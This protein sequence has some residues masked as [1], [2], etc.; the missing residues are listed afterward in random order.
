MSVLPPTFDDD[1]VV[2]PQYD[3]PELIA[4]YHLHDYF[5]NVD[6]GEATRQRIVTLNEDD[7]NKFLKINLKSEEFCGTHLNGLVFQLLYKIEKPK[8]EADD[9]K[10]EL[11]R[12]SVPVKTDRQFLLRDNPKGM[13]E[14]AIE[15]ACGR[16]D[17]MGLER[18]IIDAL[19]KEDRSDE[20]DKY[21]HVDRHIGP[22]NAL[23][24]MFDARPDLEARYQKMIDE[25]EA[26][27]KARE[28]IE[29]EVETPKE[30]WWKK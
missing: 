9:A 14:T 6:I 15:V 10:L 11:V 23:K 27:R 21:F 19:T 28:E 12:V 24:R 16:V 26:R 5:Y 7:K 29:N 3:T 22:Q 20:A 30:Q 1:G 25:K 8:T 13:L 17:S 2:N 4:K 18:Y